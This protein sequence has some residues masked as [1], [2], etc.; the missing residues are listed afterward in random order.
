[1]TN[2]TQ[3]TR[4]PTAMRAVA[5]SSPTSCRYHDCCCYYYDYRCSYHY[6]CYYHYCYYSNH[7]YYERY[8]RYTSMHVA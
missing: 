6:H 2:N 7:Y 5:T 4:H 3:P 8:G 1:M